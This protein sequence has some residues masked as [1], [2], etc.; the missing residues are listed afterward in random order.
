[1]NASDLHV[2]FGTGPVGMA[3]MEALVAQAQPVRLV[4]RSA[5][6]DLPAG[7]ALMQGDVTD[8]A[9]AARAAEG[10]AVIYFALNPP[11]TEWPQRFPPLLD[12]VMATALQTG[13]KLVVMDNLYMYGDTN[14]APLT[15]DLPY[16]AHTRKGQTRAAMAKSVLAAH[17]KGD[18]QA[19]IARAADFFGPRVLES[20]LGER[21]FK[22]ALAGKAASVMG[23]PDQPHTYT[24]MADIGRALAI[25][26]T[27]DRALGEVWH[28]PS[29]PT[30]TT[31]A[32]I[33]RI[34]AEI[35][36]PAQ[37]SAMPRLM[38]K[39]LS[40]FMPVLREVD[41]MLYE[42]EK[43]F[44]MDDSKFK[45]TFGDI[46]TDWDAAIAATVAWYRQHEA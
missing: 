12:A 25:L 17:A 5:T 14:G 39:G 44:I 34:F 27:D 1:M 10:A 42:F 21:V 24:Y 33:D 41:E 2:V 31:R 37:V 30:R 35:G 46:A 43:P 4:N 7:V 16:K 6:V 32:V 29:P 23:D 15:E 40:L 3:T 26:G 13:A 11:Y 22:P 18:V 19:T 36:Q 38:V 45:A 28:I 20:A 8:A 9:F